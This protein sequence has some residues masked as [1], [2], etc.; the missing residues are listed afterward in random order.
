MLLRSQPVL[1]TWFLP[2]CSVP[3]V[4]NKKGS[5][6]AENRQA[7]WHCKTHVVECRG[8]VQALLGA[9]HLRSSLIKRGQIPGPT[10]LLLTVQVLRPPLWVLGEDITQ[11]RR[12]VLLMA[13]AH[14]RT[15][16]CPIRSHF[17]E[18]FTPLHKNA[19]M[20][21]PSLALISEHQYNGAS[22]FE[23]AP[24]PRVWIQ[25]NTSM[26]AA[27][28]EFIPVTRVLLQSHGTRAGDPQ[29]Q[30]ALLLETPQ[31]LER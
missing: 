1:F 27:R 14:A 9:L 21:S 29:G 5:S 22:P 10:R 3:V 11:L 26:L 15:A 19:A 28:Y 30:A 2:S 13:A 4:G 16:C 25:R 12:P 6:G 7:G 18:L 17:Q 8:Q 24:P 20:A 23:K 31:T